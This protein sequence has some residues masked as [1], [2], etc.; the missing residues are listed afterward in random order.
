MLSFSQMT[1]NFGKIG[2]QSLWEAMGILVRVQ[3]EQELAIQKGDMPRLNRL[4]SEQAVAWSYIKAFA[5]QLIERGE[6]SPDMAERLRK[7]LKVHQQREIE[8][9]TAKERVRNQLEAALKP[10]RPAAEDL[11]LQKA[12]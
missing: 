10:P 5:L 6:A 11:S 3:E 8:L 7:I 12:A 2:P 1:D 9:E 4:L